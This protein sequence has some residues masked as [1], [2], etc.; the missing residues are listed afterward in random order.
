MFGGAGEAT[1]IGFGDL[2]SF[3]PWRR[4]LR[5]RGWAVKF[6]VLALFEDAMVVYLGWDLVGGERW[7]VG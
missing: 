1:V 5:S 6:D 2:T 3:K 7:D 4:A